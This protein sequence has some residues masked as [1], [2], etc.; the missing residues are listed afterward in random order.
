M[1]KYRYTS[2]QSVKERPY[3]V[4]P[5]WRG[6]GCVM[7]ILIPLM[8][9]AGAVMLYDAN[10][11]NRWVYPIPAIK[12]IPS[13]SANLA[14]ELGLTLILSIL[15]FVLLFVLYS[16]VYRFVGPSKYGPLDSPPARP[17]RKP[18]RSR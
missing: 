2:Q 17:R 6:I 12:F 4:H 18:R 16:F 5:I 10:L 8:S 7:M 15:G 9:Y 3:K 14:W 1:S 13:N 11:R